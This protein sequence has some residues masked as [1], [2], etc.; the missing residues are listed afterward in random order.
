M[1]AKRIATAFLS[2]LFLA[3]LSLGGYW[4]VR[5]SEP[6]RCP[7]CQR[8]IHVKS[9]A[10]MELG[11]HV[12]RACCATC[13]LTLGRQL[14]QPVRLTEVAD[15]TTERP[16]QPED[17]YF[18]QGSQVILCEHH[19]PLLTQDK[20]PSD[21]VFDRCEPSI[22]AF[23]RRE[24]AEAFATRNGGMILRLPQLVQEFARKP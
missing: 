11:G 10:V 3:G 20:Q 2:V 17:A 6:D 15:Y 5:K 14:N 4:L 7:I 12:Q 13:A 16:L 22:F 21:R 18:V 19:E 8:E 24:E 23:A 1:S 9:H